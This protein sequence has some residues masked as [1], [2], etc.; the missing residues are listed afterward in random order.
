[1][2]IIGTSPNKTYERSDGTYTGASVCQQEDNNGLNNTAAL[3]DAREQD[4]ATAV[5]TCIFKDGSN[6]VVGNIPMGSHK[7][8]GL[9]DGSASTDSVAL[10]QVHLLDGSNTATA[11][12][13]MGS[14]KIESLATGTADTD[15]ATTAQ[16]EGILESGTIM[17]FVQ[18]S[19]PTGWTKSTTYNNNALRV[20]SGTASYGGT[21]T[22]TSVF[23]ARTITT[24]NMPTH[25]H[26]VTDPG[27][28]HSVDANLNTPADT[29]TGVLT[30]FRRYPHTGSNTTTA[31][32]GITLG[33]AGSGTPMDF[34]V[35]YVDCIIATRD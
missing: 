10:G 17:L 35:Q 7:L 21:A 4:L 12:L 28:Y 13:D 30:D 26:A 1:M 16:V 20:V 14:Y 8:T 25:T 5:D 27:H 22:F 6:T 11:A 24:A 15:A 19:A 9:S 23:T 33:N 18:T 31:T 29:S 34:A 2:P 3:A 32:T